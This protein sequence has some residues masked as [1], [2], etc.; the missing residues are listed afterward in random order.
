MK[1]EDLSSSHGVSL[2]FSRR[3][4]ALLHLRPA[5]RDLVYDASSTEALAEVKMK[6]ISSPTERGEATRRSKR[7]N[8]L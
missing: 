8:F 7:K 1:D 4:A 6:F 2:H 5:L 3:A